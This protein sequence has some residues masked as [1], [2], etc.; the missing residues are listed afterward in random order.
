MRQAVMTAPGV[1]EFRQVPDLTEVT[2]N[3]ILL[4]V[5]RIGV[6]GSDIH[7]YHG[8]HPFTK[9]PVIQG[10][11]YSGEVIKT[12][13]NLVI[14]GTGTIGNLVAQCARARGAVKV[15]V[16]DIRKNGVVE[17]MKNLRDKN[18]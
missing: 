17:A 11:E 15:L 16:T 8:K 2:D 1:I 5:K 10:H 6:C 13:K 12:G 14:T 3:E 9:Y 7:V 4:K 18:F